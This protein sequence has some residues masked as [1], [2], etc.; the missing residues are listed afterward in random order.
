MAHGSPAHLFAAQHCYALSEWLC[1]G[2]LV[3]HDLPSLVRL[4]HDMQSFCVHLE[5]FVNRCSS[6]IGK[7]R[8]PVRNERARWA[9]SQIALAV[10]PLG[11]GA[12]YEA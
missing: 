12:F 1:Q 9:P 7:I 2:R 8:R 6:G 10:L 4:A 11:G 5:S 3:E